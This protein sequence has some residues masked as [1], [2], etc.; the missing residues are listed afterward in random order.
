M[1]N[2]KH[3]LS[4]YNKLSTTFNEMTSTHLEDL[5]QKSSVTYGWGINHFIHTD[6][7]CAFL[8]RIPLTS[9]EYKNKY[10]TKNLF[11]L[12]MYYQYGVG[13]AGFG[14]F[15]ELEA[16]LKTSQWVLNGEAYNFPLMYHHRIVKK[17]SATQNIQKAKS[18]SYYKYWNN[19]IGIKNYVRAR[20]ESEYELLLFLEYIPHTLK[21]W[22]GDHQGKVNDLMAQMKNV[23]HFLWKKGMIHMDSHFSNILCDGKDFFLTDFGLA[24]DKGFELNKDELAFF[25]RH[26]NYDF[27]ELLVCFTGILMDSYTSLL[28]EDKLIVDKVANIT[29]F[30]DRQEA[31]IKLLEV[32]SLPSVFSKLNLDNNLVQVLNTYKENILY[33]DKF[34]LMLRNDPAKSLK[35]DS[36][37]S[38]F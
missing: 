32:I 16:N 6:N 26:K 17:S 21:N 14:A 38:R 12:P 22:I 3:R 10:S 18:Q 30:C 15:R 31:L 13:S 25:E 27:N 34:F 8:K 29:N 2:L 11:D 9:L 28:I 1:N 5:L 20:E 19:N 24:L 23:N 37:M 7:E 35:Y 36:C 4:I 33:M